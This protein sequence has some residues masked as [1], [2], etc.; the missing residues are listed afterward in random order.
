MNYNYMLYEQRE[1]IALITLNQPK[2]QNVLSLHLLEEISLC[3]RQVAREKNTTVV[4]I[5]G[6]GD[7][8]CAGHDLDEILNQDIESIRHLFQT[9]CDLMTLIHSIPQPV[10]AQVS[11][12]ATAAGCQFAA[13][14]D[15]VVA[16]KGARFATPGVKIGLF[17]TT[18][19]VPLSR[20]MGRKKALE[21]LLTGKYISAQEAKEY[22]LV[23]R[24]ATKEN[25][26]KETWDLAKEIEQYSLAIVSLGKQSFYQQIDMTEKH[27]YQYAKEVISANAIMDNALGDMS[28]FLEK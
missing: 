24:V 9:C 8:F 11:G 1:S 3:F 28:A 2:R 17:C 13:A 15:L 22:G 27:A 7:N 6:A 25:L 16:E 18:P 23:N 10:I 5:K 12:I 20:T 19:I 14:C 4:I 21:M 26:E